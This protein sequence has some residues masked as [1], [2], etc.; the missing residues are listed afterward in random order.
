MSTFESTFLDGIDRRIDSVNTHVQDGQPSEAV[1]SERASILS[2]L[3]YAFKQGDV[4]KDEYND[5]VKSLDP[6]KVG[7]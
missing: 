3:D 7:E 2:A 1:T 5:R 6:T 4:T